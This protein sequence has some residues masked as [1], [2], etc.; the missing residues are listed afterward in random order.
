MSFSPANFGYGTNNRYFDFPP[1][2][3]DS[4]SVFSS[5]NTES[6]W[7]EDI[8]QRQHITSNWQYRRYL[9]DNAV[10]IMESQYLATMNDTGS[11]LT[12]KYKTEQM[13]TNSVAGGDVT[14]I[15]FFYTSYVSKEKPTGYQQSD[16]KD[17]YLS[18]E[19][20]FARKFTPSIR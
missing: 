17:I 5:W 8:R 4:R 10:P 2:M 20:L 12:N 16:L 11:F 1:L 18:R 6:A 13:N 9:V 15:P 3:N 14:S 7:N 19:Q